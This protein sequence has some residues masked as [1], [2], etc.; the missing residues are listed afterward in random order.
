MKYRSS[1]D[2]IIFRADA[3]NSLESLV[4]E[5]RDS[6]VY[7]ILLNPFAV[8]FLYELKC[9]SSNVDLQVNKLHCGSVITFYDNTSADSTDATVAVDICLTAFIIAKVNK[10]I[11][12]NISAFRI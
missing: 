4:E 6:T 1:C 7:P 11:N 8:G 5:F 9:I 12:F 10:V 2:V 3:G